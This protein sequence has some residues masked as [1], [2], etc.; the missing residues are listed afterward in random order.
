MYVDFHQAAQRRV[1]EA[2]PCCSRN[3][4]TRGPGHRGLLSLPRPPR[5][6]RALLPAK[7]GEAGVGASSVPTTETRRAAL[8]GRAQLFA[9]AVG[10]GLC[11]HVCVRTCVCMRVCVH[12]CTRVCVYVYTRV[13][14][15]VCACVYTCVSVHVCVYTCVRV[16]VCVCVRVCTHCSQQH[17]VSVFCLHRSSLLF[18]SL[19]SDNCRI[20]CCWKI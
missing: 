7:E 3:V 16:H 14:A 2:L 10:L 4:L 9:A 1:T 19:F 12:V 11:M 18:L 17:L 6:P 15:C 5:A 8:R 20:I 13:C